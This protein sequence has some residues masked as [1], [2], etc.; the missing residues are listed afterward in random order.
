MA[1][2]GTQEFR[3]MDERKRGEVFAF[4]WFVVSALTFLSLF[5]YHPEDVFFEMSTPNSPVRNFVGIAGAYIAWALTFLFGKTSFFLVPLFLIWALMKWS[6]K[7]GQKLWLKIF[8]T[9]IFFTSA[10]ALFSLVGR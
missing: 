2:L 5:S 10:C 1:V 8:S 3:T 7:K 4:F 9:V 6:G